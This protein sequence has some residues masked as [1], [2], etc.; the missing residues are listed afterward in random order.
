MESSNAI[1]P[2]RCT[3]GDDVDKKL[4]TSGAW[5]HQTSRTGAATGGGVVAVLAASR[6]CEAGNQ[7]D[8]RMLKTL[9][10]I[11]AISALALTA[12][13][14]DAPKGKGEGKGK[15]KRGEVPAELLKKYDK[16]GDGK[17][18]DQE[19]AAISAEDRAKMG[20]KGK[21]KGK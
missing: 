15:G 3:R 12:N 20:G 8:N 13:A 6:P 19:R 1:H 7:T 4:S 11:L 16:N 17:L 5:P 18:D 2:S 21:G 14:E 9:I 10:P